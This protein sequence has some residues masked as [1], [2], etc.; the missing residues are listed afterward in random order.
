MTLLQKLI[1]VMIVLCTKVC[2][3]TPSVYNIG[4][5]TVGDTTIQGI[6]VDT[7]GNIAIGAITSDITLATIAGANI[8]AY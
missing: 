6:A 8:A 1:I 7:S 3:G 2:L 5:V 4:G